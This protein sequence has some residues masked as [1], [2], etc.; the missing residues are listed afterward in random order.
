MEFALDETQQE[1]RELAAQVLRRPAERAT[2]GAEREGAADAWAALGEADLLTLAVPEELGGAGLGVL[3]TAVVLTEVGRCALAVPAVSCLAASVLPVVRFGT[4]EQRE[5]LLKG[6][7]SGR[8]LTAALGEPSDPLPAKPATL[9]RR[10]GDAL[11]LSGR[12]IGVAEAET[13]HRMLVSVTL[14]GEGAA[15][16]VVDPRADGVSPFPTRTSSGAVEHTVVLDEVRIGVDALLGGRADQRVVDGAHD[17]AI[18]GTC[19]LAHGCVAG[20]LDLTSEY[21]GT[22]EQF[23]RPLASFQ[24]VAGQIADVYIAARTIGLVAWSA[25]WSLARQDAEASTVDSTADAAGSDPREECDVAAC[26]LTESAPQ[27]LRTCHH[28][29]GGTGVDETYPLHRNFSLVR[30]AVRSVGGAEAC[31]DRLAA[32]T[33]S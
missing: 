24:S 16:A 22:R 29:H 27:A 15:L 23:G 31:L 33:A 14:P 7:E 10:D 32:T 21:V 30:D 26:W 17:F 13:A 12:K 25:C 28:L 18:A 19:A 6:V 3:E 20:A 1:I 9:A 5:Q 2:A 4:A 8:L 11:V